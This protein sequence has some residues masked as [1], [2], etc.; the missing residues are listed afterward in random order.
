[1]ANQEG[2]LELTLIGK[3]SRRSLISDY[4]ERLVKIE[5]AKFLLGGSHSQWELPFQPSLAP[6]GP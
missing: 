6:R 1:M 4:H 5:F 3:E 2:K